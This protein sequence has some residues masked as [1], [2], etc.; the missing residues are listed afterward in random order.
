M[1]QLWDCCVAG[2]TSRTR[3]DLELQG[4]LDVSR[5]STVMQ[6]TLTKHS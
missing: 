6:I 3:S 2:T 1:G 5:A 4:V